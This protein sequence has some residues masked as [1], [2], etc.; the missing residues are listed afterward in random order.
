MSIT[1]TPP[2][3]PPVIEPS[4]LKTN[5]SPLSPLRKRGMKGGR[6]G[7]ARR[8]R[9]PAPAAARDA[10]TGVPGTSGPS[11]AEM[12]YDVD[13]TS[14]GIVAWI[15]S[16]RAPFTKVR[17]RPP[18]DGNRNSNRLLEQIKHS[19]RRAAEGTAPHSKRLV[20]AT[21]RHRSRPGRRGV[22]GG[23]RR[24]CPVGDSG[25]N[26]VPCYASLSEWSNNRFLVISWL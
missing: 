6:D 11:T 13:R 1:Q 12:S 15:S 10:D 14:P 8:S 3:R 20:R 17:R 25:G 9:A 24:W 2:L 4:R 16:T 22:D 7:R 19:L 18:K 21:P 26:L 5:P 23:R